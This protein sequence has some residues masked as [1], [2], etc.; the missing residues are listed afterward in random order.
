[1]ARII[2]GL[3][4]LQK[5]IG[6]GGGGI[7]YLGHHIRL[8]KQVVLKA[9]KRTL[10]TESEVL[11]R[12]VDLLKKLT[13]TYIPQVYDFVQED[14]VVYTVMDYI[15]GESLDKLLERQERPSQAQLIQW[16]C[17]LLEALI[18]LHSAPPYGILHGD[19]K[20]ANIMR[21]PNGDLCLIDFNIALALGEEGAVNVG[22]SRGYASPEHY[23][24]DYLADNQA[25]A[26]GNSSVFHSG[27]FFRRRIRRKEGEQIFCRG[28]TEK[29]ILADS[30]EKT[31]SADGL[32]ET[33][34]V[35]GSRETVLADGAE[36]TLPLECAK[37]AVFQATGSGEGQRRTSPVG[38]TKRDKGILLDVRSDI[39]SLGATLYHLISG[40]RP[41][42]DAREVEPLGSE[43]CSK[44]V[45][46][47][48]GKAMAPQP[49]ERY[50]RAEDMLADFRQLHRQDRRAL[51]HRHR[52]AAAAVVLTGGFL[53][54]G[55]C[56]FIGLNQMEQRQE[57]LTLAEYSANALGEGDRAL[58]VRLALQA[59]PEG[60]SILEA[61]VTAQ[62]Q[63][64]LA[65]ALGVYDLRDGFKAAAAITLPGA[66]FDLSISPKGNRIAVVYGY[67]AAVYDLEKQECIALLPLVHSALADCV[68][69]DEEHVVYAGQEGVSLYDL[70]EQRVVWTGEKG[71]RLAVSADGSTIA[72]VDGK[73]DYAVVYR[74]KD[75]A[76]QGKCSFY[77]MHMAVAENDI[78]ADPKDSIFTLNREGNLLAVSFSKGELV[79]FNLQSNDQD[80]ILCEESDFRHF[81]G[82]FCEKYF[83][84]AAKNAEG[85]AQFGLVDV[86]KGSWTGRLESGKPFL[87]KA[88]E[89]GICLGSGNVLVKV[90]PVTL[91]EREIAYTGSSDLTNFAMGGQYILTAT[92][93]NSFSFYDSG[94]HL[95][96]TETGKENADFLAL[97]E[98][99]AVVGN[100]TESVLRILH[101]ESRED[102]QVAS[103]DAH[104]I[105][106][107][108]RIS[109]DGETVILFGNEK[110]CVCDLRGNVLAQV[111]LPDAEHIYDQQFRREEG[112]SWLE[113]IWY[114]GT[115]RR[116]SGADGSLVSQGMG[117][118]PDKDLYE[119]FYVGSYRIA[120]SLHSAPEVYDSES[121]RHVATLEEDAYLTYVTQM[122]E[123]IV[124]EYISAAGERYGL[125]LDEKFQILAYLPGLCDV[126]WDR[127]IFDYKSGSLRQCPVFTLEELTDRGRAYLK[128]SEEEKEGRG[129]RM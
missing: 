34:P 116:Y 52:M 76:V 1:M 101:L 97:T 90:D 51:R 27:S 117:E 99:Y 58:A 67:E 83:S 42:Q 105:H 85:R 108:A 9:D 81:Q 38:T 37:K 78:F 70:R 33:V 103:Y 23:G 74:A 55:A 60:D 30:W 80:L 115:V 120:S 71:K 124:T 88:D 126:T 69:T 107:E 72:A 44:S 114:D 15:Q 111:E 89:K 96:A 94:A 7:V 87:L 31:A 4:E 56:T 73:A 45:A 109:G 49:R 104:Y 127:L 113:V 35:N 129:K 40:R 86:E 64:A 39:Y 3:Y 118:A 36:K 100:R 121:G 20:P 25:A 22:F 41:A 54:G 84:F 102:A 29:G 47:I 63:K 123:Y 14:G 13:H 77:G 16:A 8:D 21:K 65:D 92:E 12:E 18:Y 24:A 10:N 11:R 50:Q 32:G 5:K 2:A 68:F 82:G 66:P 93:D 75:G 46:A 57:A 26:V 43:V 91:D 17:Q 79:V 119:E 19:I 6:S 62:A 61:P 28:G 98:E 48:L 106:E 53:A 110:F 125:L 112:G 59:V 95:T 122:G 128:K